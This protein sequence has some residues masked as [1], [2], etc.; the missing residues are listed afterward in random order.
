MSLSS[1]V[2]V[3]PYESDGGTNYGSNSRSSH[4]LNGPLDQRG[5]LRSHIHLRSHVLVDE[6]TFHVRRPDKVNL[7]YRCSVPQ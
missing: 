7:Q 4:S 2:D 1:N 3:T 5:S 6:E